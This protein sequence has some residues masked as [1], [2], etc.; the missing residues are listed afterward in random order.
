[1]QGK[2][3]GTLMG[4]DHT[5]GGGSQGGGV[6]NVLISA[7]GDLKARQDGHDGQAGEM[8]I[9][10]ANLRWRMKHSGAGAQ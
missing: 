1:M 5:V 6:N 9:W 8:D 7:W 10:W 3:L 4:V 2:G